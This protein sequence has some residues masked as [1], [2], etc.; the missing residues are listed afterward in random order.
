MS[1]FDYPSARAMHYSYMLLALAAAV[2]ANPVALPQGVTEA[3]APS[4]SSPPGCSPSAA[5]T[6]GI[7]VQELSAV[8]MKRE[9]LSLGEYASPYSP[10]VM[11][12]T[13][14][15]AAH[16]WPIFPSPP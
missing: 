12:A 11:K 15:N 3:I 2:H 13:D 9:V 1:Y 7:A 8:Q 5:G 10:L 16:P 6:Y 4:A 14:H